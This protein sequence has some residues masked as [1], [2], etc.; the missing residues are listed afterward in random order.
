ML[1][2]MERDKRKNNLIFMGI[3]EATEAEENKIIKDIMETLVEETDIGYEIFGRVGRKDTSN[4]DKARPLRLVIED[5]GHRQL[6]LSR[7]KKLKESNFKQIF[8]VPDLTR[9]QQEEDK[10]LRDKLKEIRP[11]GTT[12]AKIVKGEI[13]SVEDGEKVVLFTLKK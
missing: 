7:G 9:S 6:V 5:I 10:K 12:N 3:K 8:I 1:E 2:V 11:H 13:V 4:S